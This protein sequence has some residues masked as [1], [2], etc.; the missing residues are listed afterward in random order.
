MR[1]VTHWDEILA[2]VGVALRGDS[3]RGRHDLLACWA[4]TTETD[5]ASAALS[6]TTWPT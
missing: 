6:P 2:A 5:H 3:V 1:T 4:G